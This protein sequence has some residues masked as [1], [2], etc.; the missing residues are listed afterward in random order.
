MPDSIDPYQPPKSEV[1]AGGRSLISVKYNNT[2]FDLL[3]FQAIHQFLSPVLQFFFVFLAA[4][5]LTTEI[6]T[7]SPWEAVLIAFLWYSAMWSFQFI[8]TAIYLFSR[9]N[10][11]TFATHFIEIQDGAL[12]EET[13]YNRSHFYWNEMMKVVRRP[14]FVAIYINPHIAHV[15]PIRAF[16]SSAQAIDFVANIRDKI[17]NSKNVEL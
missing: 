8:F 4:L 9:K 12:F 10:K 13:K 14:G 3:L 5:S 15:I 16:Q 6:Q 7:H 1:I 2:L 17:H 11:S